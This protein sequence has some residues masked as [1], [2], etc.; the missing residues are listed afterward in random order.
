[1]ESDEESDKQEFL[2]SDISTRIKWLQYINDRFVGGGCKHFF[3]FC[4]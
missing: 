4:T 1:M 2:I 3:E